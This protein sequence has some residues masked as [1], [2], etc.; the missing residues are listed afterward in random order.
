MFLQGE[1]KALRAQLEAGQQDLINR[2]QS[3]NKELARQQ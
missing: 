2:Q 3:L 1:V